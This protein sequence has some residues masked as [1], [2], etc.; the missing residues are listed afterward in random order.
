[1]DSDI[2]SKLI[3]LNKQ[4]YQTFAPHFS[5]TRGR[6]QPGVIHILET[7][8]PEAHILDLGCGNGELARHLFQGGHRG[9]Y[10]GLDFSSELLDVARTG[11][12]QSPNI[13]FAQADL[14]DPQWDSPFIDQ[15][16]P[17]NIV[18]AFATLHHLPGRDL[19]LQTLKK[20]RALLEP[21]GRLIHSN[22]QF[23]NSSRMNARIQSWDVIGLRNAQVDQGDYLLD[24]RRG[25]YGLRYVHQFSEGELQ[26]LA[27]DAG[28]K[29]I[30]TFYSDGQ[31]GNLGLYQIWETA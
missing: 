21:R 26:S 30:E 10:L 17:F 12:A 18:L 7:V 16:S 31:E 9:F 23:L 3:K 15:Q 20:I 25:G 22:W 2:T 8:S 14:S 27:T 28:F 19:H 6:L 13:T 4:F 5:A 29:V 24:W 1:M 11:L